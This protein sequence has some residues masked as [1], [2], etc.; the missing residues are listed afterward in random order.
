[1]KL[2]SRKIWRRPDY[3]RL[4]QRVADHIVFVGVGIIDMEKGQGHGRVLR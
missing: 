1:M 3:D 2:V 4:V